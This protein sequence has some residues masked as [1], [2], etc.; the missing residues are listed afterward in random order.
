MFDLSHYI[1]QFPHAIC[2]TPTPNSLFLCNVFH[3]CSLY[4]LYL[5]F[6][7]RVSNY[8]SCYWPVNWPVNWPI[9][10]HQGFQS[11]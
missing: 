8:N 2:S 4:F 9:R 6:P 1:C 3:I 11:I 10:I 7:E 5:A